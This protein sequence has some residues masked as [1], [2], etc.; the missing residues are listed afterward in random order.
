MTSLWHRRLEGA[1]GSFKTSITVTKRVR[2]TSQQSPLRSIPRTESDP[3][4]SRGYGDQRQSSISCVLLL[5][6]RNSSQTI[7]QRRSKSSESRDDVRSFDHCSQMSLPTVGWGTL[8]RRYS[9]KR[10]II[11]KETCAGT[12]AGG[13]KNK[14]G[15]SSSK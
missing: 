15:S 4:S 14:E 9:C 3:P 2:T 13:D 5:T 12:L 6:R 1:S 11:L 8:A 7:I 10:T